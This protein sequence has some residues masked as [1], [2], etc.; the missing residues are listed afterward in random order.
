MCIGGVTFSKAN[1]IERKKKKLH[2]LQHQQSTY[3][4]AT[5]D[6]AT[7]T[8]RHQR[9][10]LLRL[11]V[12][13]KRSDPACEASSPLVGVA[14]VWRYVNATPSF[15]WR[16]L[17]P[18]LRSSRWRFLRNEVDLFVMVRHCECNRMGEWGPLRLPWKK[19]D[20][21]GPAQTCWAC[22]MINWT[23]QHNESAA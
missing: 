18:R 15:F 22:W 17:D 11:A 3:D 23:G 8:Q 1:S 19:E 14:E 4:S 13:V 20:R 7:T 5:N 16:K 10:P 2:S 9:R 6:C 21:L 12:F